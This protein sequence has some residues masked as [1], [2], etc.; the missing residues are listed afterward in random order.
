MAYGDEPVTYA[1]I[2]LMNY[3]AQAQAQESDSDSIPYDQLNSK[4]SRIENAVHYFYEKMHDN[5]NHCINEVGNLKDYIELKSEKKAN[6]RV[7]SVYSNYPSAMKTPVQNNK[8]NMSSVK[9]TP[10][11]NDGNVLGMSTSNLK[12]RLSSRNQTNTS[13]DIAMEGG[14]LYYQKNLK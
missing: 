3:Q 4:L 10:V 8:F 6:S 1:K 13:K 2:N 11:L 7:H 12:K 5:Y 14:D 9:N